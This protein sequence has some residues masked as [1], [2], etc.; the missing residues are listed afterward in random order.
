MG[1]ELNLLDFMIVLAK[2]K[3]KL[4][5][6]FVAISVVAV[7]IS[8]LLTKYYKSEVV[9]IP[10]GPG[11]G[12]LSAF[13]P[14]NFSGDFL[15]TANLSKRQY[16]TLLGSRELREKI[17][18]KFDLVRVYKNDKLPNPIDKTLKDMKRTLKT[19]VE[20]EGGLGVTNVLSVTI[21]AVDKD[22]GRASEMANY[23][24]DLLED[25]VAELNRVESDEQIRYLEE[26]IAN[27]D[28]WLA[29]AREQKKRFQLENHAYHVPE[30]IK[31]VLQAI[32]QQKAQMLALESQREYL[33]KAHSADYDGIKAIDS[34][35]AAYEEEIA[36]METGERKDVFLGLVQSLDLSE[37]YIDMLKEVETY[38][39]LRFLLRAQ[40]EQ[41]RVKRE[42]DYTGIYVV[43]RA[44]P[45]EYK[46]KPKRAAVVLVIVFLYMFCLV[47]LLLLREHHA[48]LREND[49]ERL[50]KVDA[51]LANLKP[52]GKP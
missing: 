17:I 29:E 12:T 22:P 33:R 24:F 40:L 45:A 27:C 39:Q 32:G 38:L 48:H 36:Q 15:A 8:L 13:L 7:V 2:H 51:L 26:Q 34:K 6:N 10:Q 21:T 14:I 50:K 16:V 23:A 28:R 25:K 52:F 46:F 9:F 44:R 31:M 18:D 20:E 47:S 35:I 41:S 42:K 30:Q 19:E 37:E 4:I 43:D 11:G 5:V 49:P 1:K 3:V